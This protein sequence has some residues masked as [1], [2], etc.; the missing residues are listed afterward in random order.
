MHLSG[1][2]RSVFLLALSRL[3]WDTSLWWCAIWDLEEREAELELKLRKAL[4]GTAVK[5]NREKQMGAGGMSDPT[6]FSQ[7]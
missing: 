1:K 6:T 4:L 5:E 2:M 3:F 7:P